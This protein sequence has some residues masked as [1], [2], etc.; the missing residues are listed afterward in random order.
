MRFIHFTTLCNTLFTSKTTC[1]GL[2]KAY[3]GKSFAFIRASCWLLT[4]YTNYE[5][6]LDF[7]QKNMGIKGDGSETICLSGIRIPYF[8]IQYYQK[9]IKSSKIFLLLIQLCLRL[10]LIELYFSCALFFS[11]Q[12]FFVPLSLYPSI[13][14]RYFQR[15]MKSTKTEHYILEGVILRFVFG[16]SKLRNFWMVVKNIAEVTVTGCIIYSP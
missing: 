12:N 15:R 6:K 8:G 1:F 13:R 14:Q 7:K 10:L 9:T 16:R 2:M 5:G 3:E 11:F 4:P